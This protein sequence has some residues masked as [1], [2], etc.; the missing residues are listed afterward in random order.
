MITLSNGYLLLAYNHSPNARSP[1]SL[2][3]SRN[4]GRSWRLV[5]ELETDAALQFAYPTLEQRGSKV[6]V[7]YS[8]MRSDAAYRLIVQGI[9]VATLDL[10]LLL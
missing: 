7:I 10:K 6:H 1:L 4:E 3:L 5:G 8:V 2:A 9:K